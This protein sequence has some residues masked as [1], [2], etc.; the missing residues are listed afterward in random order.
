[1]IHRRTLLAAAPLA[2]LAAP[3]RAQDAW[4]NRAVTVLVPLA[5]FE[6]AAVLPAAT[7]ARSRA[8]SS[9]ARVLELLGTPAPVPEPAEPVA[10]PVHTPWPVTL[11]NAGAH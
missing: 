3:L 5:A 6:A 8:L 7:L 11:R 2:T 9:G 1:M 10:L 4:P